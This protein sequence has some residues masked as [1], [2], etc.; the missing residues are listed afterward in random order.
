MPDFTVVM[1]LPEAGLSATSL[2]VEADDVTGAVN[3]AAAK[4][5]LEHRRHGF[6]VRPEEFE[7][8]AVYA[9]RHD[10]ILISEWARRSLAA[11]GVSV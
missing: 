9:G 3:A 4:L 7:P 2:M 10:N 5:V 1:A 8:I 6:M 11:K